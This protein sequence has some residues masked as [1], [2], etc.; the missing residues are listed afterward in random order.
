MQIEANQIQVTACPHP[1][2]LAH[3][4]YAFAPTLSLAQIL[5]EVQPD[6]DLLQLAHVWV[7]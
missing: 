1:F 7:G 6:S 2:K 5:R 4:D 3:Q